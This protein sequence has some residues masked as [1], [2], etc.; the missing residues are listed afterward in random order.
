MLLLLLVLIEDF[1][2]LLVL[3]SPAVLVLVLVLLLELLW[4]LQEVDDN[5]SHD[6][7]PY[8]CLG[9]HWSP[10]QWNKN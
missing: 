3:L 8:A 1:C 9:F 4:Q 2:I 10:H 6:P 5:S 7:Y